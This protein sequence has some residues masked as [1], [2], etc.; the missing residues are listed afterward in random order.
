M[1]EEAWDALA[2]PIQLA[3]FFHHSGAKRV[4]AMYPSPA[5]ATESLLP[6]TDWERLAG[7]N[8]CLAGMETDVEALLVKRCGAVPEYYIIPIDRCYDLNIASAKYLYALEGGEVPLLFLFSGSVFFTTPAGRLQTERVSWNAECVHRMPVRTWRN[9]M[10]QHYPN[11]GWL[12]LEREV[13][14]RL[15]A[16]KRRQGLATWEQAI[17]QLLPPEAEELAERESSEATP[18][19]PARQPLKAPA[20]EVPA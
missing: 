14:E 13:F 9:L 3:F 18:L 19:A 10:E 6:L 12:T 2:L 17:T 20:Q 5:G 15:C 7:A 11:S 8:P 16:Y 4:V 1:S